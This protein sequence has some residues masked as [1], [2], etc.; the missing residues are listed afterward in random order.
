MVS[1][2]QLLDEARLTTPE[3]P[4]EQVHDQLEAGIVDIL[5]DVRDAT[6]W[7]REHIE[8]SIHAPRGTLEWL[9]DPSYPKH[10][11]AIAGQTDARIV[12]LC[13]SGGRS[14]LAA[15]TLRQMGYKNVSS[16]SG[17]LAAWKNAGLAVEAPDTR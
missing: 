9:A 8:G 3:I 6:E 15:Q 14:V 2:R 5:L 13:A 11:P 7:D 16:M 1:A 4:P 17:G 10:D 12:V